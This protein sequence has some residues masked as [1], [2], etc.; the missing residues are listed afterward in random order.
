[1]EKKIRSMEDRTH[2][3]EQTLLTLSSRKH[4]H[5]PYNH[6]VV[7]VVRKVERVIVGPDRFDISYT[8]SN[9]EYWIKHI[10]H[11][12]K[13][14]LFSTRVQEALFPPGRVSRSETKA[15]P[16]MRGSPAMSGSP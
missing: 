4:Q 14:G 2:I 9:N 8:C 3:N 12:I 11:M 10:T 7:Q 6:K 16:G 15:N 13:V 1:M 5:T